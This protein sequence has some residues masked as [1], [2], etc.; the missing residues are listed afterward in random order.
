MLGYDIAR[1]LSACSCR[2]QT[3]A[4]IRHAQRH[5]L[6]STTD[7]KTALL[8]DA[9]KAEAVALGSRI[10]GFAHLRLY[11]SPVRRCQQTAECIAEGAAASGMRI[12]LCGARERLGFVC[13]KDEPAAISLYTEIGDAFITR[14]LTGALPEGMMED[15]EETVTHIVANIRTP[16][17][18]NTAH[19]P[20][21]DLHI[22]HDW[23]IM[24]MRDLLL[25]I[26]HETAGWLGYLD[27]LIFGKN[28]AG[29]ITASYRKVQANVE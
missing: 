20:R 18:E 13:T 25:G 16:L 7:A 4:I 8:T 17:E 14:W 9:G 10:K 1:D 29:T 23:N 2:P 11:H 19:G 24:V 26:R 12:E 3:A 21:L 5:P 22:S 6:G 27:G 15:P 28:E